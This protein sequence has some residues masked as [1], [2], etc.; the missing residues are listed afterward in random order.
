M[1]STASPPLL[2]R[3]V[4][5]LQRWS[6]LVALSWLAIFAVGI[7]GVTRT[8]ANLKLQARGAC[9]QPSTTQRAHAAA[10]PA[11]QI[12]PIAGDINSQARSALVSS[13][14]ALAVQENTLV[15]LHASDGRAQ[16]ATLPAAR[17]AAAQLSAFAARGIATG[18]LSSDSGASYYTYAD[19]GL[20][21]A[22]GA[23]SA[24]GTALLVRYSTTEGACPAMAIATRLRM[25][26]ALRVI[27]LATC[28]VTR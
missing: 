22:A 28:Q 3:Y 15:M 9:Q 12:L 14:P 17:A 13:F 1:A 8:F 16:L 23:I 2:A 20:A 26:S 7:V 18:L 19:A 21:Q 4:R 6:A 24:D 25:L 11:P 10:P 5:F 27:R